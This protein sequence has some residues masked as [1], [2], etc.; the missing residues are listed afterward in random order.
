MSKNNSNRNRRE[1]KFSVRISDEP[2]EL[3][4]TAAAT[5]G[6]YSRTGRRSVL[7][8]AGCGVGEAGE[9]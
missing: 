4:Q 7:E 6:R 2:V 8:R 3:N 5:H 9:T 1:S